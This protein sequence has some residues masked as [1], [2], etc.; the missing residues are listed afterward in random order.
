L[1]VIEDKFSVF[2]SKIKGLL[3]N[4]HEEGKENLSF[5][6]GGVGLASNGINM[7]NSLLGLTRSAL[8][9]KAEQQVR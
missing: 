8:L 7:G 1:A 6:Q 2:S 9:K 5:C 3:R 4:D